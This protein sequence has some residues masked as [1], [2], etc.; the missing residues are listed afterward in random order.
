MNSDFVQN[1]LASAEGRVAKAL[2]AKRADAE[3]VEELYLATFT[4][5]PTPAEAARA[6]EIAAKAPSKKEGFEDLLWALMNSREFL[7]IH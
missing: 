3:I 6:L 4:R 1:K 7:F 5:P 2:A